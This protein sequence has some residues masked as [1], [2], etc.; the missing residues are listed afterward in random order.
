M[1]SLSVFQIWY[2]VVFTLGIAAIFRISRGKAAVSGIV[3][4]V[5]SVALLMLQ[6]LGQ[7]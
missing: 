3:V 7:R 2:L 4:W 5:I 1:D 6:G